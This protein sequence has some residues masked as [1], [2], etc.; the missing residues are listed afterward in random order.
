MNADP[1]PYKI[2]IQ[3]QIRLEIVLICKLEHFKC[4]ALI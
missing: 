2:I 1:P 3:M 4:I